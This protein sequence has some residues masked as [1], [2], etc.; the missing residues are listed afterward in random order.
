V[1]DKVTNA[2][3]CIVIVKIMVKLKHSMKSDFERYVE[4]IY[5][6]K[7]KLFFDFSDKFQN[8]RIKSWVYEMEFVRY[9]AFVDYNRP[10]GWGVR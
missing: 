9:L 8:M 5:V 1:V 10:S 2:R 6:L 4:S 7:A 3:L